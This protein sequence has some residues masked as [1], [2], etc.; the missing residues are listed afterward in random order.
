MLISPGIEIVDLGLFFSK[1][2][3]LVISD[4][5]VGYEEYLN[6]LG[7]L[8]PRFQFQELVKK[9]ENIFKKTGKLEKIIVNGDLKHEFGTISEQEWRE[10]LQ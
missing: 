3:V 9:L 4:I 10:T 5:H 6:K 7:V 8:V 1:E 2:K